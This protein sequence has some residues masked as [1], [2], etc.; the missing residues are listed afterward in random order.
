MCSS[1]SLCLCFFFLS[2]H[3]PHSLISRV[4]TLGSLSLFSSPDPSQGHFHSFLYALYI[5]T[6]TSF[7]PT[8]STLAYISSMPLSSPR[9]TPALSRSSHIY[10]FVDHG[11]L[12]CSAS[13]IREG[14]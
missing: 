11:K 5:H 8:Y 3:I 2:I 6:H 4:P 7:L 14:G 10:T 12:H 13:S 9:T 1:P